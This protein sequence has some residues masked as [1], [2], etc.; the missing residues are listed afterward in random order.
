MEMKY[1]STLLYEN[2]CVII[3]GLGGFVSNYE[4]AR[5]E[6]DRNRFIPP[7]KKILFN[8]QLTSNDGLL[9]NHI[10]T[11]EGISYKEAMRIIERFVEQCNRELEEKKKVR[12]SGIGTLY[13]DE[14]DKILFEQD[15]QVNY[16]PQAYGL[17][18]F[19]SPAIYRETSY[20]RFEKQM[21]TS[22]VIS[23]RRKQIARAMKWAAILIPVAA[24]AT[25][26]FL[27][28]DRLEQKYEEYAIYFKPLRNQVEQ[29]QSN[30]EE[31][32]Q[33]TKEYLGEKDDFSVNTSSILPSSENTSEKEQTG[34]TKEK[35]PVNNAD[36][37]VMKSSGANKTKEA[38]SEDPS[39]IQTQINQQTTYYHII[40]GSFAGKRNA[41]RHISNLND[42]GFPAKIA[43]RSSGGHYR[44]SALS[45]DS[46]SEA[47]QKLRSIR[48]E[49]FNN[50]W[51]LKK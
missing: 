34:A 20:Q 26:S 27:N 48:R 43:G 42:L 18:Q 49:D 7:H 11:T 37:E 19:I 50:A 40:T 21:R 28:F 25:W 45:T 31:Q 12:F 30:R 10:A 16:L 29:D 23:L 51:L 47:L 35:T 4:P 1:I 32:F 9:A 38:P 33:N 3:P 15:E 13:K 44:V 36:E 17:T 24:I 41:E 46:K 39:D 5:I 8:S 22:P 2:D 6:G 14:N